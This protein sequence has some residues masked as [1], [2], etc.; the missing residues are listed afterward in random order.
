[1]ADISE[2]ANAIK[3]LDEAA[4]EEASRK[5]CSLTK[6]P[7]SLGVLED[8]SVKLAGIY[9]T[10]KPNIGRKIIFTMAGDH[11]VTEEGVSA[12]PSEVTAQMVL[13]FAAGGAAINVLAAC[14]DAEVRVVDMGVSSRAEWPDCVYARKVAQGTRNMCLGPA[15]TT[16]EAMLALCTGAELVCEAVDEGASAI[17]V[18][19]MGIGNT[20][21][22]SAITA[23]VTGRTIAEVTGRGT[24]V[25]DRSLAVKIA[26]IEKALTVNEPRSDD[27]LDILQKVGGLEIGGMAGAII[28]A[29]SRSVPVFLDGFVSSSAGLLAAAIAPGSVDYMV[30]SHLSVETGHRYSLEHLGLSPIL[31]LNMRL[32]EGTGAAI[33][34]FVAG[35]ACRVLNEMATFDGA[36]VSGRNPNDEHEK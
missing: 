32:G 5:Q 8:L 26:A 31:N 11:G 17:A 24:G 30:S 1:M 22:A 12:Y 7:G 9:R 14:A 13:N 2:Y 33:A 28:G 29:S 20:T 27:G 34:F 18:G 21:A 25:T 16:D 6:P 3:P 4:M 35:S 15:M 23:A 10:A 19:D 36:G